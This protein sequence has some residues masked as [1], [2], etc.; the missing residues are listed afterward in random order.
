MSV[1]CFSERYTN[2]PHSLPTKDGKYTPAWI[3]EF[4]RSPETVFAGGGAD[5]LRSV[6][7]YLDGESKVERYAYL[8]RFDPNGV[9]GERDLQNAD[10]SK[11]SLGNVYVS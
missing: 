1:C 11:T 10:G 9:N 8:A 7:Q 6:I 4:G 5:F 3:T 2:L